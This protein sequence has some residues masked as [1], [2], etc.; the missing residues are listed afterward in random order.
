MR[1]S[2][3][4]VLGFSIGAETSSFCGSWRSLVNDYLSRALMNPSDKPAGIH[5][6]AKQT[7]KTSGLSPCSVF[8]VQPCVSFSA[9]GVAPALHLDWILKSSIV[10]FVVVGRNS[11]AC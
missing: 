7:E 10:N 6:L 3:A 9:V 11:L 8:W 2:R 5:G 1:L 4:A